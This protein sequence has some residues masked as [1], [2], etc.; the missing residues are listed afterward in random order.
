MPFFCVARSANR[1][2]DRVLKG[3]YS[4][5]AALRYINS[6]K[7]NDDKICLPVALTKHGNEIREARYEY[8]VLERIKSGEDNVSVL[9]NDYGEMVPHI[10]EG[11]SDSWNRWKIVHK[12][13]CLIEEE[14]RIFGDE[15]KRTTPYIYNTYIRDRLRD[16]YSFARIV[17]VES[18]VVIDYDDDITIIM[19]KG[20]SDSVRLYNKLQELATKHRQNRI[21][22]SGVYLRSMRKYW[23][24]KI[25]EKTG[26]KRRNVWRK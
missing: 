18:Q 9:R 6:L 23:E 15:E 3:V 21:L 26:W 5:A 2:L 19:T 12:E 4:Y 11:H 22:W 24:D 13:P 8:L 1:R 10:V 14:F 17:V 20:H 16:K 25:I 7:S